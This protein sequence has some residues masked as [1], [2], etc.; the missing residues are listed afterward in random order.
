MMLPL[1]VVLCLIVF[2]CAISY[3]LIETTR[4]GHE[5][6]DHHHHHQLVRTNLSVNC[7]RR[8]ISTIVVV[9]VVVLAL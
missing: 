1:F 8:S 5:S 9:V 3:D 2:V 7:L 6:V 4:D